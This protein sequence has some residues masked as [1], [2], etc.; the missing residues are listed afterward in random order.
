LAESVDRL[1]STTSAAAT[2]ST[3]PRSGAVWWVLAGVGGLKLFLHLLAAAVTPYG[4]H[5]DEFLYLAMGRHLEFWRMDFPPAIGV[6]ARLAHTLLGDSLLAIRWWPAV[7]GTLVLL[8]SGWIAREM[9]GGWRAQGLAMLAVLSGSL[10]L[11]SASL[12]QPVVFDQ[13]WWT[14]GLL[15]LVKL[16]QGG[17]RRWWVLLGIAGGL[18]L[19]TKFSIAFFAVGV[20]AGLVLTHHRAAFAS[21]WPYV[22]GL[23]AV[24]LGSASWIGQIRLGFPVAL[25]L[26]TLQTEQLRHVGYADYLVG[27]ILMLGPA[28]ILGLVGWL[29]VFRWKNLQAY[30]L[31]GWTCLAAFLVLWVLHGKSYYIGPIYPAL[32]AAGSVVLTTAPGRIPRIA[33]ASLAAGMVLWL[34]LTFPFGLPVLPPPVMAK[35]AAGL[36]LKAA[37]TTNRGQVLALPQDYADMLGWQEQAEAVARV[38][39][40]LPVPDRAVVA[41]VARNYGEAGA[42]EFYCPR[43]GLPLRVILPGDRVLWPVPPPPGCPVVVT[44]GISVE[45]LQRHFRSVEQVAQFDHPWMVSEERRLPI[46]VARGPLRPGNTGTDPG[47]NYTERHK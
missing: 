37:V 11:R 45:D 35:Y 23:I 4:V 13:L 39:R 18:G 33:V 24:L 16:G 8:L 40:D 20:L 29:A 27:Q 19:L 7:A 38:C 42:L 6:L 25:H 14:L 36:G 10:F 26:S 22:A 1:S 30:R 34:V 17:G 9:G 41:L 47:K 31:L 5:R 32:F 21:R 43:L 44:L 46:C 2:Q 3:A 12:F 28:L 15:A